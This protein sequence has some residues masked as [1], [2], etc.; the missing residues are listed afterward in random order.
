MC[1]FCTKHGDGKVWYKNAANYANDLLADIKRRRYIEGFL[2]STIADGFRTLGRLETLMSKKGRL[3]AR[4]IQA[5]EDKARLEHF[6]QVLPIE[7][8]RD[9]VLKADSVVR[10]PCACRWTISRKEE[11]CCYA[12]SYTPDAW[13]KGFDMGYFGKSS[14]EGLEAVPA[15]EAIQQMELLEER[16][17]IHS[18]W[19]MMTP[20]I[21]AVCNCTASDCIAIRTLS[22]IGAHTIARA[23]HVAVIDKEL[24]TGCG[25]CSMRCQFA[26]IISESNDGRKIAAVDSDKCYGCGL[27]RRACSE[28]AISL[29]VRQ[30]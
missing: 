21:G 28:K 8:I 13:Y 18:I 29:G 26:A 22:G 5:M 12:L 7:E 10:M 2:N 16:G 6:G 3:P 25:L 30:N 27:C 15:E 17:A 23:E 4:I 1:E 11:R 9:I 19:T 24:C 20:F 14:E